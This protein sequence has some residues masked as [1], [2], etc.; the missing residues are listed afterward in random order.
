VKPAVSSGL[1]PDTR[2]LASLPPGARGRISRLVREVAVRLTSASPLRP[3]VEVHVLEST[4]EWLH[5]RIE[6]REYSVPRDVAEQVLVT[7]EIDEGGGEAADA[8]V[9]LLSRAGRGRWQIRVVSRATAAVVLS[10]SFHAEPEARARF[11]E[12]RSDSERLGA[13]AFR[14]RHNLP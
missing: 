1:P 6:S 12:L 9:V 14:G 10:E 2:R 8:Y 13:A 5:V 7:Q 3:G 4:D 11:E